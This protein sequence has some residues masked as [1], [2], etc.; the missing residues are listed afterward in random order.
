MDQVNILKTWVYHKV[1]APKGIIVTSSEAEQ[2]Y[3]K[4]WVDNPDKFCPWIRG[5]WHRY[6]LIIRHIKNTLKQFWL[7]HW[8]WL[9]G[10]GIA[11]I[12]I[13]LTFLKR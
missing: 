11:I 4:G 8:K 9:I 7:E 12:G 10:I 13:L 1:K 5:V 2:W 6:I 3:K